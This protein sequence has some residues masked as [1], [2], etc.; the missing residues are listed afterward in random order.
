M[1]LIA[2]LTAAILPVLGLVSLFAGGWWLLMLPI[3]VF[4]V[5]PLLEIH[6]ASSST[7][8]TQPTEGTGWM[9][10]A[11]LYLL[12]GLQVV[13]SV[14]FIVLVSQ[15]TLSGFELL[16]GALAVGI[17][18]GGIG[19]NIGHELGHRRQ[20]LPRF[21]ARLSLL[22]SLYLHFYIEHNKG[23]HSKVAT[24]DDPATARRGETVY[25]FLVRTV[26]G[27]FRSAWEIEDRRLSKKGV[28][29][30]TFS[31]RNEMF[32]YQL[33]HLATVVGI[34]LA[35][36]ASA[37][38][39]FVVSAIFGIG[40]LE[41]TN[42]IQHYGLVREQKAN[43]RYE[44]VQPRH[45]WSS[46]RVVSRLLLFDLGLHADHHAHPKKGYTNLRHYEDS[47]QMPTGYPGMIVMALFPPLWFRVMDPVVDRETQRVAAAA[48]AA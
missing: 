34:A 32:R 29:R 37:A 43:G 1:P 22:T 44:R 14:S 33:I 48:A 10:D 36:G 31:I 38:V 6:P 24:P 30:P 3:F 42:Y 41:V 8:A 12:V 27:S 21:G 40:L 18:A 45:S 4:G 20:A 9:Y 25:A 17:G 26:V 2:Y 19:I 7:A 46:P 23:H 39:W 15:G 5:V 11:I 47:P 28:E 16:G 13:L 35:F